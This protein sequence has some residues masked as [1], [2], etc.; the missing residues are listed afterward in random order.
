MGE[1]RGFVSRASRRLFAD[2]EKSSAASRTKKNWPEEGKNVRVRSS[3]EEK[4][5]VEASAGVN[6]EGEGIK[7][8]FTFL[9]EQKSCVESQRKTCSETE[10]AQKEKEPQ[11][12]STYTSAQLHFVVVKIHEDQA[13]LLVALFFL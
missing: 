6:K 7:E 13:F 10:V 9:G 3:V 12:Q 8:S 11:L 1:T 2:R 5:D 4:S